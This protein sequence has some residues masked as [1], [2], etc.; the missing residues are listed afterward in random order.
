MLGASGAP[1]LAARRVAESCETALSVAA[2]QDPGDATQNACEP[3]ATTTMS[4][5]D[6]AGSSARGDEQDQQRVEDVA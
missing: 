5:G 3:S 6:T 4:H 1:V 2:Q